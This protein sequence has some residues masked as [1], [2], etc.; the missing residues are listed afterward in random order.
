M[1][2]YHVTL[3]ITHAPTVSL[4]REEMGCDCVG[5]R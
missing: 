3:W 4:A 1:L 2:R 5:A